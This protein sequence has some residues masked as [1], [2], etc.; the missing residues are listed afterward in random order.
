MDRLLLIRTVSAITCL[1]LS[2]SLRAEQVIRLHPCEDTYCVNNSTIHGLEP[3][4]VVAHS[5][6][7]EWQRVA[8]LKFDIST[9]P[10]EVD[11]VVMRMYTNGWNSGDVKLHQ[12]RLFPVQRNDWAEDDISYTNFNTKLGPRIDSPILAGTA[13]VA[14]GQAMAPGWVEWRDANL[15]KYVL[16]SARAAKQYLSFRLRE[17]NIV[18]TRDNATS[19][20]EFHSKEN[21][22]GFAPELI[23]Y[24]PDGAT[25]A[26]R[27]EKEIVHDSTEARLSSI[28]L[29]GIPMEFFDKDSFHYV[30]SLPYSTVNL[31]TLSAVTMDSTAVAQVAKQS[32]IV[33]SADGEHQRTYTVDF[34]VLPKLDLFLA[35]GQSNMAGRAPYADATEWMNEVYLATP[36]GGMEVSSNPMNKYSNVRKDLSVQGM[37]PHYQFALTMRDSLP[38][39]TVGMMVNAQGGTSITVWYQPGKTNYDKTIQRARE[40]A[41][42]GEWKGIIWHQGESDRSE[43]EKDNYASYRQRLSTMVSSLRH[44]LGVDTLWFITG[45]LSQKPEQQ[46]FNEQVV[47][48]VSTYIPYSDYVSSVGTSL[49]SDG[50]H[51]DAASVLLM[52][53]RYAEKMLQHVYPERQV[54]TALPTVTE[55]SVCIKRIE[56]GQLILEKNGKRYYIH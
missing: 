25:P 15:Q 37:G 18:K 27:E 10:T 8:Y 4:M 40:V 39:Q 53:Q 35:I 38:N 28:L 1:V 44:D 6:Y 51:F 52:G 41:R 11:S 19:L 46:L 7:G 33:T 34:Q 14:E 56:Q 23:V 31:P 32:I 16:D 29:D 24:S 55:S 3:T 50:I 9:V 45:E 5:Q 42:W 54:V 12:F 30:V 22:S 17:T 21:V 43:G 36:M 20:V 47:Q 2:F 13:P 49:L 26:E 48:A